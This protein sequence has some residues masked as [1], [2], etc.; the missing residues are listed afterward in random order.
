MRKAKDFYA[1]FW[2]WKNPNSVA[3]DRLTCT[4]L[5]VTVFDLTGHL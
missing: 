3:V 5:V 1:F 2:A 4:S